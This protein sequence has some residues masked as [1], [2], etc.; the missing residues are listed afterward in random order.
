M[1]AQ[2]VL[3]ETNAQL[4]TPQQ[5][6][7]VPISSPAAVSPMA[8]QV[9]VPVAALQALGQQ[10]QF[11]QAEIES[12]QI[13]QMNM[14]QAQ[15]RLSE[16]AQ[17]GWKSVEKVV[18][19]SPR[20]GKDAAKAE[21]AAENEEERGRS[22]SKESE[23]VEQGASRNSSVG[24]R[25][26]KT[27]S[28][29]TL[30]HRKHEGGEHTPGV[31]ENEQSQKTS[32]AQEEGKNKGGEPGHNAPSEPNREVAERPS[33]SPPPSQETRSETEQIESGGPGFGVAPMD[34]D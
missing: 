29:R 28:T 19:D 17:V 13:Q 25:T 31:K 24:H 4:V 12:L 3:P 1:N 21:E 8:A 5:Q 32:A 27:T 9:T 16:P 23:A 14:L 15:A 2:P 33:T 11:Q 22:R 26:R 34:I 18:N 10:I 7:S 30:P 20:T 6:V